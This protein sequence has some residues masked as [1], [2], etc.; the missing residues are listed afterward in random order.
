[1]S[2]RLIKTY[3]EV[4]E[5]GDLPHIRRLSNAIKFN[6]GAYKNY[7]FF[8]DCLAPRSNKGGIKPSDT[9]ELGVAIILNGFESFDNMIFK[10][11]CEI[12]KLEGNS[13]VWLVY[14]RKTYFLEIKTTEDNGTLDQYKELVPL[15]AIDTLV[16]T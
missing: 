2:N 12:S 7:E 10:L 6:V 14:N 11:R 5:S 13:W 4:Q 8:W 3:D 1:M 15:L 16:G 9:S